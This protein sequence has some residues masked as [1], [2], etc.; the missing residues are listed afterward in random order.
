MDKTHLRIKYSLKASIVDE[1]GNHTK[2]YPMKAKKNVMVS[3][4]SIPLRQNITMEACGDVKTFFFIGKGSS[5][6]QATFNKDSF[7]VG[8]M[9]H[10]SCLVDNIHCKKSIRCLKIKF[11]RLLSGS[12]SHHLAH[13]RNETLIKREF[14]GMKKGFSGVI[15]L[16]CPIQ[17]IKDTE[18]FIESLHHECHSNPTPDLEVLKTLTVPTT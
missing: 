4:P 18:R 5:K 8:E 7:N 6:L 1:T 17:L 13:K 16:E 2:L 10:V 9:A 12:V 14:A 11:R 15:E 3:R